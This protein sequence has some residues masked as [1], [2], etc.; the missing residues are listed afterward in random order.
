MA[1]KKQS[2]ISG[3]ILSEEG[4][5]PSTLEVEPETTSEPIPEPEELLQL[6]HKELEDRIN[7]RSGEIGRTLK[8][9]LQAQ[10]VLQ[11]Q[12]DAQIKRSS[13]LETTIASNR[14]RERDRELKAVQDQPELID[15]VQLRHRAEDEW[16]KV[17]KARS[18]LENDMASHQAD[19]DEARKN[20]AQALAKELAENSGLVSTLILQIGT[21]TAEDGRI[22]YNLERMKSIAK[23]VPKG[24]TEE[25]AEEEEEIPAV[26]GQRSRAAGAG[27][28][29]AARGLR[30]WEDHLE[31]FTHGD[32]TYEQH[33][34]DAKRFNVE[35]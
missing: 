4:V 9:T 28:Q 6:S 13:E 17:N 7:A 8:T 26:K 29:P 35:L 10:A 2:E 23:S 16:E 33:L 30:T 32:R 1:R 24:E 5:T 34:E 19:L 20:K 15:S 11:R 3:D 31:A 14:Q 25:E 22:S 27:G 12:F 21:D 18:E